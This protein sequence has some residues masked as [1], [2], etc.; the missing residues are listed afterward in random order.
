MT[1]E[2][3]KEIAKKKKI[4]EVKKVSNSQN[5]VQWTGK[6]VLY[7]LEQSLCIKNKQKLNHED[8]VGEKQQE[9]K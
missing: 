4:A 2:R 6:L 3:P 7:M 5:G 9:S 1:R 8:Y